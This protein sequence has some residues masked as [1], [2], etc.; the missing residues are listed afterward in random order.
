MCVCVFP[1]GFLS[2]HCWEELS[3][4]H[5]GVWQLPGERHFHSRW[6]FS[7]SGN[8]LWAPSTK[9]D[10]VMCCFWML[11][12]MSPV[13][14][15]CVFQVRVSWLHWSSCLYLGRRSLLWWERHVTSLQST[16]SVSARV[17]LTLCKRKNSSLETTCKHHTFIYSHQKYGMAKKYHM[18]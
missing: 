1:G 10:A 12:H 8:F 5:C 2:Q 13:Y 11:T 17:T 6:I 3:D 16:W 7:W 4:V 15:L 18:M 9:N 14:I